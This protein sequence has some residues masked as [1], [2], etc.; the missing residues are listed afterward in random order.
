MLSF[1]IIKPGHSPYGS[2]CI[3]VCKPLEKDKP[4]PPQFVVDYRRLNTITLGDGYPIPSVSSILDALSGG[5]LF[6][7]LDLA[8]GYWQV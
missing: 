8:S 4:Q 5:K 6:A 3:L 7:K 2:P 1:N